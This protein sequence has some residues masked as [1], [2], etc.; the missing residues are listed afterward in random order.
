MASLARLYRQYRTRL[1]L[2]GFMRALGQP[3]WRLRDSL[4]G[5]AARSQRLLVRSRAATA[6]AG[7]AG[8]EP[9]YGYRRVY[10]TLR[11][12]RTPI[13][14]ERIRRLMGEL[15]LQPPPPRKGS[16]A[17]CSG[18]SCSDRQGFIIVVNEIPDS[19]NMIFELL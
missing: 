19:S 17:N 3:Y 12:R 7:V 10:H 14:R 9:T 16:P 15:R 2:K 6:V 5:D 8:A 1:S 18:P 11:Q 4:R 13:G